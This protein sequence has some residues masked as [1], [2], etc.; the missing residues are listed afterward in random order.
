VQYSAALMRYLNTR[1][2]ALLLHA[3]DL[4]FDAKR[5]QIKRRAIRRSILATS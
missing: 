4:G 2:Q 5:R 3:N 1:I